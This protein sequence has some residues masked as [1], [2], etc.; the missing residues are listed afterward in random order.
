MSITAPAPVG[1]WLGSGKP[2]NIST[3]TPAQTTGP[4]TIL[5]AALRYATHGIHVFPARVHIA[6]K[7]GKPKKVATFIDNWDSASTT[8]AAT[9]RQWFGPTGAWRTGTLCI[10]TGK[11]GIDVIDPDGPTGRANWD[12]HVQEHNLPATARVATPGGGEHWYY[13]AD[14]NRRIRNVNAKSMKE[15]PLGGEVDVRGQGGLVFAPPSTDDRGTY[16]WMDGEPDWDNLP[17]TPAWVIERV[18]SKPKRTPGQ[19]P[20]AAQPTAPRV[21]ASDKRAAAWLS[22]KV[23]NIINELAATPQGRNA[24]LNTAAFELGHYVGAGVL[25]ETDIRNQLTAACDR[26]GYTA[27]DG[28][29]A[30]EASRDSGLNAGIATPAEWPPHLTDRPAKA[31]GASVT[32]D[33]VRR[34][35]TAWGADADAITDIHDTLDA[36]NVWAWTELQVDAIFTELGHTVPGGL[37]TD[38]T[39][40]AAESVPVHTGEPDTPPAVTVPDIDAVRAELSG[41]DAESRVTRICALVPELVNSAPM[42][43]LPA[44]DRLKWE[45][46]FE[47]NGVGK[48]NFANLLKEGEAARQKAD[49]ERRERELL[50]SMDDI[51][52]IVVLT[53]PDNPMPIARKLLAMN[54]WGETDGFAHIA[55][56]RGDFYLYTGTHW[57]ATEDSMINNTLY[58]ATEG[59][60]YLHPKYGIIPWPANRNSIGALAHALGQGIVQRDPATPD[61]RHIACEN[62]VVELNPTS[63]TPHHPQRFNLSALPY[64]YDP[65]ATCPQWEEFLST[66]LPEEDERA[67]LQEWFGYVISGR[68]DQQKMLH[69]YGAKRSGKGTIARVLEALVGPESVA[70]PTLQSLTGTFG[71]Q[72]L[73]GKT[74][75]VL[76]DISWNARDAST[77]VEVLK[78]ISGED[79]REIN[80]KNRDFWHGKLGVRFTLLGNDIPNI[81]DASGALIGRMIHLHF[82]QSFYGREDPTL[83]SRLL[84]ELTG[85]LNWALTGLQRLT[86]RGRFQPPASNDAHTDEITRSTSPAYAFLSDR[87]TLDPTAPAIRLENIHQAYLAWATREGIT[88]PWASNVLSRELISAS[89]GTVRTERKRTGP[90]GTREPWVLGLREVYAGS[91]HTGA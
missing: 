79:S 86:E 43:V 17:T 85:I 58:R 9:I 35:I 29:R 18:T 88:H 36:I 19:A 78:A 67:F 24:A 39:T 50:A 75:A 30:M 72:Q 64:N 13:R 26:N 71:E 6:I 57:A 82:Q 11:S 74:L 90:N 40:L 25:D 21:Q 8:D 7:E 15:P 48:R 49:D 89:N 42:G 27:M 23:E 65:T 1:Q 10:D 32:R 3:G 47:K 60:E 61:E 81:R 2:V 51:D 69:M 63:L 54:L 84:T 41:M 20:L 34:L 87:A 56:W 46:L 5:D 83:T 70:S 76:S 80:R 62:G 28:H 33:D 16:Q 55:W 38:H 68:T 73:I 59:A 31:A 44:A 37:V 14:P 52:G 4:A 66:V 22:K 77:A 53:A 12:T 91:L 45:A